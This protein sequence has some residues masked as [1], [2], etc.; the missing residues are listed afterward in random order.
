MGWMDVFETKKS[1]IQMLKT[2]IDKTDKE[3]D[4]MVFQLYNLTNEE[5]EIIES[6]FQE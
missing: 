1:E 6:S 4:S 3:I 2:E 5:I